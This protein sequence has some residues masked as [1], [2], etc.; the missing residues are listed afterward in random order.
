MARR[1][2]LEQ[3]EDRIVPAKFGIPWH[4]ANHLTLSLVPDGTPIASHQSN[5]FQTLDNQIGAGLWQRDLL[6]AFQTWAVQANV[7]VGVVADG[8]QPFGVPGPEQ[9]DPR[10]GDIRVGAQSMSP[11]V[12]SISVP[13]GPDLSGTLSGDVFLNST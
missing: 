11:E 10:F 1:W 12:L 6:R 3:L 7:N 8:G 2:E 4:D 5:L 13:P 9:H